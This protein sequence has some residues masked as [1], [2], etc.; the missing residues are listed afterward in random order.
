M[1]R[2][3]I[4]LII[5]LCLLSTVT[6]AQRFAQNYSHKGT[7]FLQNGDTLNGV[8][9][10]NLDNEIVQ[11]QTRSILKTYTSRN[12]LS[13]RFYDT[14]EQKDRF[15]YT[16]PY[17]RVT[18]YKTPTFFELL[19]QG[20]HVTL[21]VREEYISRTVLNDAYF[22]SPANRAIRN[23]VKYNFYFLFDKNGK[24]KGFNGTKKGLLY[25]LSDQERAIKEFLK[26]NRLQLD[27]KQDVM[28]VIEY[29]NAIKSK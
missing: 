6:K 25:L 19:H 10:F 26:T 21:L 22:Y 4:I 3:T 20:K 14:Y 15:Y 27:Q 28:K 11:V 13:F 17:G 7:L 29:Y 18:N 24:I 5:G 1:A 9:T 2:N 12:I 8:L 16:L 23:T